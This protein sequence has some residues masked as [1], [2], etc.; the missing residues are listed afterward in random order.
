MQ[1]GV[2]KAQGGSQ[3][4]VAQFCSRAV[5]LEGPAEVGA[6]SGRRLKDE[7]RLL[8]ADAQGMIQPHF[9]QG[10]V[11][12]FGC[13]GG[14]EVQGQCMVEG[15]VE[16]EVGVGGGREDFA[17]ELTEILATVVLLVSTNYC[18]KCTIG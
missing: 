14:E 2:T 12:R 13:G 9:G 15:E 17:V 1:Q 16:D 18:S 11:G 3:W 4:P 8:A 5:R 7:S 10:G 6:M